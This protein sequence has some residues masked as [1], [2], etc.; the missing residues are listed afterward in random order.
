MGILNICSLPKF[1]T[2][3]LMQG[4]LLRIMLTLL[5]LGSC[6]LMSAQTTITTQVAS[7]NDDAEEE[8]SNGNMDLGSSDLELT[9]DGGTYQLVGMRFNNINIPQGT[10]II[11]A[12]IQ[13]TTDETDSGSTSVTIRGEDT[14]N[15]SFF[16]IRTAIFPIEH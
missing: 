12:S 9:R 6:T 8:V 3:N 4:Q 11:S 16:Q 10:T 5:L 1:K 2:N 14:D 7:A 13:F 15:A